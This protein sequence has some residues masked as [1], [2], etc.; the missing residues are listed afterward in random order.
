MFLIIQDSYSFIRSEVNQESN[1]SYKGILIYC[2]NGKYYISLK[3]NCFFSDGSK[4]KKLELKHYEILS[5]ASCIQLQVYVYENRSGM[6][7]Y[8]IYENRDFILAANKKATIQ[9]S[10][11]YFK[12]DYLF[13]RNGK[14]KSSILFSVNGTQYTDDELHDGDIIECLGFRMVYFTD[15]LYINRFW[16]MIGIPSYQPNRQIVAYPLLSSPPDFYL[17]DTVKEPVFDEIKE[18]SYHREP[19][20]KEIFKTLLNNSVMSAAITSLAYLNYSESINN[21]G[22]RSLLTYLITPI[23]MTF[24]GVLLPV[25]FYLYEKRKEKKAYQF[26]KKKFLS[27]LDEYQLKAKKTIREYVNSVENHFFSVIHCKRMMFYATE[28]TDDYLTVSLGKKAIQME[29]TTKENKDEQIERKLEEI[30]HLFHH[31][32]GFPVFLDLKKSKITTIIIKKEERHDLFRQYLLETVYKHRLDEIY[33]AIYCKNISLID[34][35]YNLPHLFCG[36]SRMTLNHFRQ[37]QELDRHTFNRPVI[38]FLYDNC[39]YE[40][41][42]PNIR[43]LYFTDHHDIYRKSDTVIEYLHSKACIH[44]PQRSYF[45]FIKEEADYRKLF[46]HLG[47]IAS[48]ENESREYSFSSLFEN[49][50]IAKSY[51]ENDRKLRADFAFCNGRILDFD[52]HENGLGPHGLIGG[53]T[54]SGKSELIISMLLSLCM[55]YS[56]EYLH[57]ILIDY[58]G[59]GLKESLSIFGKTVPHIVASVSNLENHAFERL[60]TAIKNECL[61]RQKIFKNLSSVTG[62]SI[63]N[64]DDYLDSDYKKYAYDMMSHLLIVVDEFAELKKEHADQIRELIT[65]SRIGRSLGIHLILATQKPSGNISDEIWSNSRFK[66]SL[67]VFEERDS[68]DIIKTSEAAF[69]NEAGSFLLRVDDSLI[70]GRSV[71]TK[72]DIHGNDPIEICLLDN[73]LDK[74]RIYKKQ[75]KKY[76]SEAAYYCGKIIETCEKMDL[77][78]KKMDFLSHAP[79]DRIPTENGRIHLGESDDYLNGTREQLTYS[80]YGSLLV[81]SSRKEEIN[82]ILNALKEN[83]RRT[84]VIARKIYRNRVIS[85]S[86]LY[87]QDEDICFLLSYLLNHDEDI[88]LLIEDISILLSYQDTYADL[89]LKLLKRSKDRLLG[90]ICLSQSVQISYKLLNAFTDKTMIEVN[91]M[92]DVSYVFAMRSRYKGG[93]FFFDDEPKTFIPVRTEGQIEEEC[94][95]RCIIRRIPET[96]SAKISEKGIR[97]GYDLISREEIYTEKK[98][99]IVSY[100]EELLRRYSEAYGQRV[101]T[102]LYDR[103]PMKIDGDFL[104]LGPGITSQRSFVYYRNEDL[105][106]TQGVYIVRGK[107]ILLRC[108]D[109]P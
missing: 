107:P 79:L 74:A 57:I 7:S 64:I 31:I 40:F 13:L 106:D 61:N 109:E 62:T 1:I 84:V 78:P 51:Q 98:I 12:E 22:T 54:G 50:A 66:I 28:K 46:H 39:N 72:N 77:I 42:N 90:V 23:S 48:E 89:L 65:L 96:V 101:K 91:D 29:L 85:D 43:V 93:S 20:H 55:R 26:E 25:L 14:L 17:P 80:L 30:R 58:K 82:T 21:T 75:N 35:C 34:D 83:N 67:K 68:M 56:P 2:N 108:L 9:T 5:D 10:D 97:L 60:V 86:L 49:H 16:C 33:I 53:S 4:I 18:F 59:G 52:L 38:L 76:F 27:Y 15:F 95:L 37:I 11:P 81:F 36:N 63:M 6:D 104:W 24:T 94:H 73:M 105:D 3:E 44:I 87:D 92:N 99:I 70:R 19:V 102:V 103:H 8:G 41:R 100:R 71:Y 32:E 47:R 88:T 45:S 69:L